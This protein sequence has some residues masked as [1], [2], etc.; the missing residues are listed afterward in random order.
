MARNIVAIY[1]FLLFSV[2]L[3]V[4]NFSSAEECLT[5]NGLKYLGNK[6][7]KEYFRDCSGNKIEI[8]NGIITTTDDK[9]RKYPPTVLANIYFDFNKY[10]INKINSAYLEKNLERFKSETNSGNKIT[11]AGNCDEREAKEHSTEYC[12]MLGQKRAD[13]AKRYLVNL[14]IDGNKLKAVSYGKEKP[15][16]TG[17]NKEA[18]AKN[19]RVDFLVFK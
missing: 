15:I 4:I 17:H 1:M 11:I 16:D 19:R 9:C 8:G 10:N 14:G 13:S 18:W 3:I 7:S 2:I 6:I 12:L 5:K